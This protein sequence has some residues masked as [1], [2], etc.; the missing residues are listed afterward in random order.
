MMWILNNWQIIIAA[1][2]VI[3]AL[4]S[5]C[6]QPKAVQLA[7]VKEWLL[8]AVCK[9]EEELGSGTGILKLRLVYDMFVN[10]WPFVA[11]IIKFTTFSHLVDEALAKVKLLLENNI[12]ITAWI[13]TE[14]KKAGGMDG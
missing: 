8:W 2:V 9:A 1:L 6:R 11:K 13:N 10:T 7:K 4:I 14:S 5:F 3:A 12:K